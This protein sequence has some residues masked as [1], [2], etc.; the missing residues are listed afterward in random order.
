MPRTSKGKSSRSGGGGG[1]RQNKGNKFTSASGNHHDG[2]RRKAKREARNSQSFLGDEGGEE[3]TSE[4]C[5]KISELDLD[6]SDDN[7]GSECTDSSEG[8]SEDIDQAETNS[9]NASSVVHKKIEP[10]FAVAMWD[11]AQCDPKKCTGRKLA[12]HGLVTLL[13]P[14]QR[15]PGIVL[16]PLATQV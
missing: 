7:T 5:R 10:P 2:G 6:N 16:D 14:S 4:C 15:F 13:K 1:V 3:N 9:N 11:L 12:R 8:E